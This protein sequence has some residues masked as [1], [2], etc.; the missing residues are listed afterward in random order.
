MKFSIKLLTCKA[1]LSL[2]VAHAA[3]SDIGV[4]TFNLRVPVDPA[5]YDWQSRLPRIVSTIQTQQPDFL[6]VQEVTSEMLAD[7]RTEFSNYAI[8]GRG[9]ETGGKGEGTQILFLQERWELD[10]RDQGTLQLSP[11]PD[12]PGSNGWRMQWPRIFT[13]VH[14]QEKKTGKFIYVF[15]T[16]FPLLASERDLSVRVLAKAIA[17]RKHKQDPVILVGDFNACEDE[18]SI[19]YLL[20]LGGSPIALKET[21]RPLHPNDKTASF[22]DFGR[23]NNCKVDYIYASKDLKIL[24]ADMIKESENFSSDHF[25]VTARLRF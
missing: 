7:L 6:G 18:D 9:R 10:K 14:L 25:A 1:L 15:N 11:T 17:E 13:W 19:S 21:Y 24:Q 4:M 2:F 12:I 22:H 5:P 23:V 16:H 3:A 8:V 20:G